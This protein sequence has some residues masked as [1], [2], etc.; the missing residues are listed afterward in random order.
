MERGC[1]CVN[2]YISRIRTKVRLV[3]PKTALTSTCFRSVSDADKLRVYIRIVR[4]LLEDEESI[5][6]ET[7]YNRAALLIHSAS[8]RETTLQFKLCQ[9]R[10]S[11]YSRKFLEAASRYHELSYV[12]EI[13]EEER[14]HMLYVDTLLA[15]HLSLTEDMAS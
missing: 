6:A 11:D 9:A 12:G 4:L 2:E 3:L 14:R 13:D 10:I 8:D 5:Q 7:Y 1:A 15:L